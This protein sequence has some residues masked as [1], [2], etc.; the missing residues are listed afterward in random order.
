MFQDFE[1]LF[2]IRSSEDYSSA[3][4]GSCLSK[5]NVSRFVLLVF[6]LF[7]FSPLNSCTPMAVRNKPFEKMRE[8]AL[9]SIL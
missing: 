9:C 8:S 2:F 5:T 4:K 7:C 6:V 1:E 3:F